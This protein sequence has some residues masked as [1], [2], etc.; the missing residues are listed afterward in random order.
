M[1]SQTEH[2]EVIA[3]DYDRYCNRDIY[4]EKW[5]ANA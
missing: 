2:N 3:T 4:S 5:K 1:S